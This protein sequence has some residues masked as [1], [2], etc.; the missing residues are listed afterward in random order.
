MRAVT[1]ADTGRCRACV[2]RYWCQ[3]CHH[4]W[5]RCCIS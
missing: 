5:A 4:A 1:F 2:R 3:C